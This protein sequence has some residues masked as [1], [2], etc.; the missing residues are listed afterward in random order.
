MDGIVEKVGQLS[1]FRAERIGTG[2]FAT[3]FPGK[4]QD[5]SK[6]IVIKMMEKKKVQVDSILY[7]KANGKP[8]IINYYGIDSTDGTFM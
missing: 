7:L 4:F 8:N 6:E 1:I 5:V 3:V 2:R